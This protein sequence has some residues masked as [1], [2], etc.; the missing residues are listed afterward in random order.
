MIHI[1][2]SE[3]KGFKIPS[4]GNKHA[5]FITLLLTSF[6]L[7]Q[8]KFDI[9]DNNHNTY[10]DNNFDIKEMRRKRSFKVIYRKGVMQRFKDFTKSTECNEVLNLTLDFRIPNETQSN[11][12]TGSRRNFVIKIEIIA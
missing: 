10:F 4:K 5:D 2:H 1:I 11:Q 3:P 7:I 9:Q 12:Y 6:Y 8:I